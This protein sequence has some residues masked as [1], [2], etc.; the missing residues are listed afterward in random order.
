[1]A[2]DTSLILAVVSGIALLLVLILWLKVPAFAA[3]LIASL[4]VGLAGG[5]EPAA[6]LGSMQAGMAGTLGTIALIVGLGAIFGALLEHSGGVQSLAAGILHRTGEKKASWAMVATG[7][8]VSIPVFFDVG[9]IIL[10][11]VAYAL[12]KRTGKSLLHYGIPLLAGLAVTHAFIPPTP[13]PVAVA[14]ILGARLGDVMLAGLA[15][16]IPAAIIAGPLFG[17]YIGKRIHI[18]APSFAAQPA[19]AEK[20]LPAAAVVL[21]LV[22]LP[23]VLILANNLAAFWGAAPAWLVFIGHP[24]M[25]LL[26]ANAVAWYVLGLRMGASNKTLMEVTTRSLAPAGLIILVTGAGGVFKQVLTDTGAGKMV[27]G[28]F[29]QYHFPV[30]V[31]AFATAAIVRIL[32]GSATVAMITAAGM[33]AAFMETQ[34][35][36]DFQ[37]A[38]LVISVAAGASIF[39]HVNDSG[40]W[41][42]NRYFG[43]TEKQTLKSWSISSTLIAL[44]GFGAALLMYAF[45]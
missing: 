6:L 31:F 10:A 40:F 7:F 16:G 20:K 9:F 45:T 41:L 43:M 23:I 13:G 44:A 5:M 2:V 3:L 4:T 37:K 27:A 8:L 21:S 22:K 35:V 25:A 15:A 14:E 34:V 39:S 28:V 32:Q 24:L 18:P 30:I 42:V 26:I 29:E 38:L 12:Q 17:R 11:P 33:T 36:S 19:E 1:M